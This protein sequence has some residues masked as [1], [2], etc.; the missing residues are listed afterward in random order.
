MELSARKQAIL[1]AVINSYIETGE[2]IGSKALCSVLGTS[3]SSATLRNEMS[4]LCELGYLQQPH[5]SAGRIP[6]NKAYE[7][8]IKTMLKPAAPPQKIRN[9]I[10]DMLYEAAKDPV[11]I[12]GL[13][14]QFL[15][16]FTGL[17]TLLATVGCESSYVRRVEV[18]PMSRRTL[19]VLLVSSDGVAK[20][21]FCRTSEDISPALIA[22]FDRVISAMVVGHSLSE[23]TMV[24]LQ[25]LTAPAGEFALALMPLFSAVF[26]MIDEI[27]NANISFGG[28]AYG[29]ANKQNALLPFITEISGKVDVVF[30]DT[31]GIDE[32]KPTNMVVARYS[33]GNNEIG[34]IGVIGPTRMAYR[35][36]LPSIQ[37]FAEQLGAILEQTIIDMEE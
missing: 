5:T 2:P 14:A 17:T 35:Q 6:T 28:D 4:E 11:H 23:L 33:M 19:L 3:L 13:A 1:E 29:L 30:G 10:D 9:A 15:S 12:S 31:T 8:Y 36:M 37:Y 7:L 18:L 32:L 26:D 21:R 27:V 20:S 22:C 34:R 16:N 25:S 24:G